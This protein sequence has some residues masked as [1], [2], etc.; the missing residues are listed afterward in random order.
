VS[1]YFFFV[2]EFTECV[3]SQFLA[4]TDKEGE[5]VRDTGPVMGTYQPVMGTNQPVMGIYQPVMVT[6]D[7]EGIWDTLRLG[8]PEVTGN[9]AFGVA[10]T[11]LIRPVIK[12]VSLII[13]ITYNMYIFY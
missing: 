2:T 5:V 13:Y 11:C 7:K 9:I 10:T 3:N 4:A 8:K 6:M 1:E 12:M